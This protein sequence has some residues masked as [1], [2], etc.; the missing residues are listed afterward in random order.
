MDMTPVVSAVPTALIGRM[1]ASVR[2]VYGDTMSIEHFA[3][4][5]RAHWT[6][7]Y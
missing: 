3:V 6:H 1:I 2:I 7:A 4:Q 5:I